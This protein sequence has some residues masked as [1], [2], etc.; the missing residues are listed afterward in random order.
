LSESG[1]FNKHDDAEPQPQYPWGQRNT[2][3]SV[4]PPSVKLAQNP[5]V[6]FKNVEQKL[7]PKGQERV[8]VEEDKDTH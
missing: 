3:L 2:R 6:T 8:E 5:L 7:T 4:S 1:G